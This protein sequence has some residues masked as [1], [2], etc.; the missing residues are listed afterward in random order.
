MSTKIKILEF[1]YNFYKKTTIKYV[2][3]ENNIPY[4]KNKEKLG[5]Y[6][7]YRIIYNKRQKYGIDRKYNTI[8]Q[9]LDI[10]IIC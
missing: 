8:L 4:Y 9:I 2:L 10:F 6:G 5:Y 7:K 1:A 3:L